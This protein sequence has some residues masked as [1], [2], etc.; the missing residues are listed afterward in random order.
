M[1]VKKSEVQGLQMRVAIS[2]AKGFL[3]TALVKE[4]LE[5]D[6]EVLA[7]T[8]GP[9]E[10]T[11]SITHSKLT[12]VQVDYEDIASLT[13]ILTGC[14]TVVHLAGIAHSKPAADDTERYWKAICEVTSNLA[15]SSIDAGC[16]RFVFAST[17]KV[18]GED[19]WSGALTENSSLTPLTIYGQ[20]KVEA[21][22]LLINMSTEI[23]VHILRFPPM[24]G[25]GMRGSVKHIFNAARKKLP[26][27]VFSFKH[28]RH[29]LYLE[30]AVALL[31]ASITGLMPKTLYNVYDPRPWS[32]GAFYDQVF[33]AVNRSNMPW[34]LKWRIPT[35]LENFLTRIH[36]LAPQKF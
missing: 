24:F 2:G 3:G 8:R 35:F 27:P 28:K 1:G 9:P 33:Q 25:A 31:K 10:S 6:F 11:F 14:S 15:R 4:L 12:F 7:L 17:I 19:S 22:K 36:F 13:K 5:S 32:I 30:N 23:S 20:C 26:L 29:F 18:Y 21:E 16:E 34:F